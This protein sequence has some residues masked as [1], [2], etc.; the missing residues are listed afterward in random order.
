MSKEEMYMR[1]AEIV[2]LRSS[3]NR[4]NVGTVI[5]DCSLSYIINRI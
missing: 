1:I 5:V 4:L 2:A 3:C